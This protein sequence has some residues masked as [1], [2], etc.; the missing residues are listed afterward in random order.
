MSVLRDY[1]IT[2]VE[3]CLR[4][5]QDKTSTLL[6]LPTGTGKTV[7]AAEIVKHFQPKRTLFLAHRE[8]LI[9]QGA[10]TISTHANVDCE[11]EMA[12]FWAGSNLFNGMPVVIS[13]V[14]TQIAGKNGGRMTRFDPADFGLVIVDEA[15]RIAA[16]SYRR[17][18][19]YY[20][21]NKS[22]KI[23]ALTAT[24]DRADEKAL[25]Q[26]IESVAF[27]YEILDAINDG[28]LVPI[29]Q[30]MVTIEGLDFSHIRTTAGD[31]NSGDLQAVMEAEKNLQGIA[32]AS[33]EIIGDRRALVFTAGVKQAERLAEI[34]NRHKP[35]SSAWVCGA[36][37]KQE[38]RDLLNRFKHG[39]VQIVCNCNVLSEGFDDPGVEVIVQGRP[40]KSRCLYAQQAG[41]ATRPLAGVIDDCFTAEDRKQAIAESSKPSCLIVD[42]V[43]NSGRH[44]LITSA[45]ILGGKLSDE[46]IEL[47]EKRAKANPGAVNMADELN[48]AQEDI[49]REIEERKKREAARKAHLVAKA[50][51]SLKTISPF[52]VFDMT[53]VR[54]R[55]WDEGKQ[56]SSKQRSLLAKQGI[57]PSEMPYAQANQLIRELFRRWGSGLCTIKQAELLKR[58]GYD[59]KD[60]SKVNAGI[61]IDALAK[62]NWR[63]PANDPPLSNRQ[64]ARSGVP[65]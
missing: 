41:R 30:Q 59:T 44:K 36:T 50:K 17:I 64:P 4:E 53:P 49:H 39:D 33:I 62:N 1:Q 34:F 58:H 65:F 5:W 14:Q 35:M 55:G 13:T 43:G 48:K 16:P 60:L 22:L 31:L 54:A 32:A 26:V 46:V 2:A 38:R 56:L 61:L 10:R 27:D 3:S 24:P 40:T 12:E 18:L 37:P 42:F 7:T 29:E 45:D 51:F 6:V 52:D 21:Q 19:D 9:F 23:L 11:Y 28:Y 47:A 25:G 63:R 20:K 57:D 8:E 15:H